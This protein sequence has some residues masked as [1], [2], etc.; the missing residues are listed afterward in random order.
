MHP[1]AANEPV[2]ALPARAVGRQRAAAAGRGRPDNDSMV[3]SLAPL[4]GSLAATLCL[5]ASPAAARE[6]TVCTITVNSADEKEVF[7]KH[8]PEAGYRFVELIERGR[9]DWLASACRASVSC[10]ILIVSAHYDGG[11][12]FFSDQLDVQEN[13]TVAELERVSCSDSLR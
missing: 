10:D 4:I 6:Q 12:D 11:N 2:K 1:D 7:R 9:P 13:L 3:R 8:L 5:G